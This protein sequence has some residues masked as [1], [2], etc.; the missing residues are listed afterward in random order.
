MS[1]ST[2]AGSFAVEPAKLHEFARQLGA[3]AD[4]LTAHRDRL[5]DMMPAAQ[6][7]VLMG[8]FQESLSFAD[9][10]CH[11]LEYV[12][13]VVTQLQRLVGFADRVADVAADGYERTGDDA[14]AAYASRWTDR[15]STVGIFR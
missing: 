1:V 7:P 9:T 5:G 10:Q 15:P 12:F 4:A 2:P 14:A 11:V 8:D 6:G 13:D 3:Q